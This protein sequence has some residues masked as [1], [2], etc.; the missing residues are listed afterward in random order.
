MAHGESSL[1]IVKYD[2]TVRGQL[3]VDEEGERSRCLLIRITAVHVSHP[4]PA[5]SREPSVKD[6]PPYIARGAPPEYVC[7]SLE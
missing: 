3:T 2:E 6:A 5:V 7:S 1:M 4:S